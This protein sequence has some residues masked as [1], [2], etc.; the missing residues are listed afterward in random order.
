MSEVSSSIT[1]VRF[2]QLSL[3]VSVHITL[4]SGTQLSWCRSPVLH[5]VCELL[6][7]V[8]AF[9]PYYPLGLIVAPVVERF[10]GSSILEKR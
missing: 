7:L 3:A 10:Y 4:V 5:D 6:M 1:R 9:P 8:L 2:T